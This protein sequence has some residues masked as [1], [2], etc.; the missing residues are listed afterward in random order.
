MKRKIKCAP[1]THLFCV[2]FELYR[3]ENC[4]PIS[5]D[6]YDLILR[7]NH[8]FDWQTKFDI[9]D[10]FAP[11]VENLE[12]ELESNYKCTESTVELI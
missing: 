6:E 10:D 4:K 5:V 7:L 12:L 2:I 8:C 9:L 11:K 3:V 1:Q